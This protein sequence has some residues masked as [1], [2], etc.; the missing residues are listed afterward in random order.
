MTEKQ[1]IIKDYQA[2]VTDTSRFTRAIITL[3]VDS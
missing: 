1:E 3:A 2:H